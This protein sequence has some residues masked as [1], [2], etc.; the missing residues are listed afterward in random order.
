[1]STKQKHLETEERVVGQLCQK[2]HVEAEEEQRAVTQAKHVS[3]SEHASLQG[4]HD[5]LLQK[6]AA[7]RFA[8]RQDRDA[9]L[10][11]AETKWCFERAQVKGLEEQLTKGH[12]ELVQLHD[13]ELQC[14]EAKWET[15]VVE[16]QKEEMSM[17]MRSTEEEMAQQQATDRDMFNTELGQ[18]QKR[19]E[20]LSWQ[21]ERLHTLLVNDSA[22]VAQQGASHAATL[23]KL[24]YEYGEE[25]AAR[26]ADRAEMR[27]MRRGASQERKQRENLRSKNTAL[28]TEVV[29]LRERL[30]GNEGQLKLYREE[31]DRKRTLL[32]SFSARKDATGRE[33]EAREERE[34]RSRRALQKAQRELARRDAMTVDLRKEA[35]EAR[36]LQEKQGKGEEA[37]LSKIKALASELR[38]KDQKLHEAN[39]RASTLESKLVAQEQNA[40]PEATIR[41]SMCASKPSP[42]IDNQ[43]KPEVA[44]SP[45]PARHVDDQVISSA[46]NDPAIAESIRILNLR[47]EDMSDFL[48]P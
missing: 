9:L 15:A 13:L 3:L 30:K 48:P 1:M 8:W 28:N 2:M 44:E 20:A 47:C 17:L 11:D 25:E 36:L 39:A 27:R 14:E 21:L 4:E 10:E 23:Q 6:I 26:K 7:E 5:A 33:E 38:K 29:Q 35:A 42:G 32:L 16:Q 34:E 31:L 22:T 37:C 41:K 12:A 24:Q 18:A 45:V 46:L 40:A 19:E 43:H